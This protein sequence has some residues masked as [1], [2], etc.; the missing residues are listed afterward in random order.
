MLERAYPIAHRGLSMHHPENTMEACAAAIG[1]APVLEVDVRA[2]SDCV[3][4]CAHDRTLERCHGIDR[5]V[6]QM[7]WDELHEVAP[8]IPQ[9]GDVLHAFGGDIG[10]I[11]DCKVTRPRAIAEL[12][13]VVAEVGISW[14]S[15]RE[16]RHGIPLR[17]GTAAFE[18][19]DPHLLQSMHS[20]LGAG[21]L[22]LVGGSANAA[23]LAVT[24]PL[25]TTYAQGVTLP[26]RLASSRML[27]L[28]GTL[29]LG[30]YVYTINDRARFDELVV[31][32]A[33]GI[34]TDDVTRFR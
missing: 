7:T 8:Q 34:F 13:R 5:N 28:L 19:A 16:L 4:V 6:G 32:G 12:E 20:R 2:T 9:L 33:S 22:E 18:S 17:P 21:V 27:G 30:T 25:I 31:D 11:I 26:D 10:W 14:D 15:A 23:Q 1:H 29:R 24:A 3:L